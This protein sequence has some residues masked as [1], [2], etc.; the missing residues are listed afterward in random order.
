M[1]L[2]IGVDLGG[3]TTRVI[4]G[5]ARARTLGKVS[6]DTDHKGGPAAVLARIADGVGLLCRERDIGPSEVAAVGVSCGGPLD[7]A[8]GVVLGPP[9]LPGWDEVPITAELSRLTGRP[10][11]LENDANAGAVAEWKYGAG[12]GTRSMVFI[13]AGT[14]FGAGL[15]LGGRL[16]SGANDMAGE[17]GHV[18]LEAYGPWGYGKTGTVDALCGGAGMAQ[19]A[20]EMMD[21]ARRAGR[22][23]LLLMT[24][25]GRPVTA[26]DVGEAAVAGDGLALEVVRRVGDY[27][28]QALAVLVDVVNPERVVIGSLAVRLGDLILGPAREAL[29]REALPRGAAVCDVVPAEL[30]ERLGDVAALCVAMRLGKGRRPRS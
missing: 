22:Q 26:R 18:R 30:G 17:I 8:A 28:G 15:I 27:W 24:R 20:R 5:D 1:A 10:T 6:F 13:T 21:T 7:S 25:P 11:W 3:T 2:Y 12:R 14:G 4:I 19:V 16:Y 9:N 29:R 23:S